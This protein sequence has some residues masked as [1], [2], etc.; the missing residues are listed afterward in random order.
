M[1]RASIKYRS[2]WDLQEYCKNIKMNME[3][4]KIF[5]DYYARL[6]LKKSGNIITGNAIDW[7]TAVHAIRP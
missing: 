5:G 1:L 7:G 3:L 6:S 2:Q 4:S